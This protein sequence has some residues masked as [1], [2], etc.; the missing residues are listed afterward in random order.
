MAKANKIDLIYKSPS[1]IYDL[2]LQGKIR[3]FPRYFWE[4]EEGKKNAGEVTR[5]LFENI[6]K[7]TDE[8]IEEKYS[9]KILQENK[10]QGMCKHVFSDKIYDAIENAYPEK[11][12]TWDFKNNLPHWDLDKGIKATKWLIEEHLQW[13]DEDI[14][15]NLTQEIFFTN[16]LRGMLDMCFNKSPYEAINHAY[17][18]KYK[19]WEI[20]RV[21]PMGYWTLENRIMAT[22]WLIEEKLKLSPETDLCKVTYDDFKNNRLS[23]MLSSKLKGTYLLALTEAYPEFYEKNKKEVII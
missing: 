7:W 17:P 8:E 15:N 23:G 18:G 3:Q 16:E 14:K 2:L 12:K 13:S 21:V 20:C 9:K 10:L 22:K 5:H 4:G 19:A 1:E 6:L 11:F